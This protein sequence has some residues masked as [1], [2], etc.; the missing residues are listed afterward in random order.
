MWAE[1]FVPSFIEVLPLISAFL[2]QFKIKEMKG[3]AACER[4]YKQ[5]SR[6]ALK[7][8]FVRGFGRLSPKGEARGSAASG[9]RSG[10]SG[11]WAPPARHQTSHP[12]L[13]RSHPSGSDSRAERALGCWAKGTCVLTWR[14]AACQPELSPPSAFVGIVHAFH[15]DKN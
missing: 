10:G 14:D 5:D 2:M 11:H 8:S 12:Q 7:G 3:K 15:H 6:G 9:P 13:S 4:L 1:A